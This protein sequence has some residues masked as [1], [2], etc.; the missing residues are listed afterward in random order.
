MRFGKVKGLESDNTMNVVVTGASGFVG[1]HM[2]QALMAAGHRVRGLS[3]TAP[4]GERRKAGAEYMDGVDITTSTTLTAKMFESTDVIVHLVGIIQEATGG[5]TFRRIHVDG[6]GNVID[7]ARTAGFEGRVIYMSA[8]GSAPDALSE[9]SRTKFEAEQLVEK[10]A[11]PYTIFRPSLVI[12]KDGE[13]V[14]QMGDLVKHGGLSMPVPFPFIPVPGDGMNKFQPIWIDDLCGCV[15]KALANTATD[16]QIYEVGGATQVTFNDLLAGFARS[17][18]V[19]K[20]MVHA[21]VPVLNVVA[22]VL[23][24]LMP[25]PPVTRD[26]LLN[27]GRDNITDSRAIEQVFGIHPLSFDQMLAKVYGA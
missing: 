5:Q 4:T 22:S 3:R 27:L 15:T 25:K 9:Y 17:L 16:Y 12:G 19:S 21:P 14:A 1:S 13:F 26:Q 24:A 11:L 23:E 2:V 6:T 20:P 10:S 18:H 7:A 8:L